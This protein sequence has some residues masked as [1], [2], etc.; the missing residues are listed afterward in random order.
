VTATSKDGQTATA[1]IDY[2]ILKLTSQVISF[3]SVPPASPLVGHIYTVSATGGASGNPVTFTIDSASTAGACSISGASVLFTGGGRC[4]LDANQAGNGSYLAAP[5][6]QQSLN[7]ILT[8]QGLATLTLYYIET[9]ANYQ[10]LNARQQAAVIATVE[11]T[12]LVFFRRIV[13]GLTAAQKALLIN[14]AKPFLRD[15]VSYGWLTSRQ[16][17]TLLTDASEL[18]ATT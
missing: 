12:V 16:A 14:D 2:T 11:H 10:A 5:E 8:S 1:S 3:A 17:T 6:V 9:S 4:V 18:L 7:V 15:V 13:P